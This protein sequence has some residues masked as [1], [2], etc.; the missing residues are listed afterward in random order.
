MGIDGGI[1]A[2]VYADQLPENEIV[3]PIEVPGYIS[4]PFIVEAHQEFRDY[5]LGMPDFPVGLIHFAPFVKLFG[6]REVINRRVI[7]QNDQLERVSGFNCCSV[8][9]VGSLD[10]DHLNSPGKVSV[11]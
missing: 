11:F 2:A 4:A 10:L 3:K 9:N 1:P 6:L 8:I 5:V 7:A